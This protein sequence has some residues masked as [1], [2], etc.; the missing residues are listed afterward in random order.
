MYSV[1]S[2]RMR[3]NNDNANEQIGEQISDQWWSLIILESVACQNGYYKLSKCQGRSYN[4]GMGAI[5]P[6]PI[7]IATLTKLLGNYYNDNISMVIQ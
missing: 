3:N 2:L 4:M 6:P 1:W 5:A 7:G